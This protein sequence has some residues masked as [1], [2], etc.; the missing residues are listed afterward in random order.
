MKYIADLHVHSSYSRATSKE[1]DLEHLFIAAK[2]KGI[3]LVGTGDFTHPEWFTNLRNKLREKEQGIYE[4]KPE[5]EKSLE[6]KYPEHFVNPVRFILVSEISNI[7]KKDGKVRKIHNLVF[8]PDLDSAEKFNTK[9]SAIGNIKSDGRPILGL[10][11]RDLLEIVLETNENA[12]L[13]PAHIWTPWFSILGSKSGFDGIEECF[14]DLTQHIFALETGLSSDPAMNWRISGL[15]GYTLISNS[16]AHSPMNLGREAN[17]FNTELSYN[18]LKKALET[19]DK[20]RFLGTFE[21]FPEEGKYHLDGHRNCGIRL[22]PYESNKNGLKCPKCGKSLTLGVMY[23]VDELSDRPEGFQ[24]ENA[25]PFKRLV[26][27][28][29]IISEVMKKGVKT[30]GVVNTYH[31]LIKELGP[32]FDI[33]ESIPLETI[34]KKGKKIGIPLLGEAVKRVREGNIDI[35][36]GYDGEYGT[37]NIF[38]KNEWD[39]LIGQANLFASEPTKQ[40]IIK[41]RKLDEKIKENEK[42]QVLTIFDIKTITKPDKNDE[43]GNILSGLNEEQFKAVNA[44]SGPLMIVAGPGTGKTRT[45]TA[46]IVSII[47]S[48]SIRSENIA[49]VTFTT[50]AAGEMQERLKNSLTESNLPLVSTFHGLAYGIMKE[51]IGKEPMI[52]D[53]NTKD[54]F[55]R[56]IFR[57][58]S[59]IPVKDRKFYTSAISFLKQRL[60]PPDELK[61]ETV[62]LPEYPEADILTL[63]QIYM[64]YDDILIKNGVLDFDSLIFETIRRLRSDEKMICS[65]Q[66]TIKSL[67]VDEFQ[68]INKSQF[69]LIKMIAPTGKNLTVIGDPNQAIYGF[70]GSDVRFFDTFIKNFPDTSRITL[71]RN[72][73][74]TESILKASS[75]IIKD[76]G[77]LFSGIEGIRKLTVMEAG[78]EKEEAVIIGKQIEKMIG[79]MGMYSMDMNK[80]DDPNCDVSRSF[81]DI[82]ILYRLSSQSH[83]FEEV[84]DKAGIPYQVA[85]REKWLENPRVGAILII[86][87]LMDLMEKKNENDD[88]NDLGTDQNFL[89]DQL[90]K[91][92]P[93]QDE[94]MKHALLQDFN[95]MVNNGFYDL[96]MRKKIDMIN[97]V[98]SKRFAPL[99]DKRGKEAVAGLLETASDQNG[100]L[101]RFLTSLALI[102]DTDLY[103]DKIQ[104][105]TLMTMHASKGLEF[106]VVFIAGCEEGLTPYEKPGQGVVDMD[107]ERRLFYVAMTRARESLYLTHTIKRTMHGNTSKRRLSQFVGEIEKVLLNH[108]KNISVKKKKSPYKQLD[109][110]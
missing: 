63:R 22:N 39:G 103:D 87:K 86:M 79:G 46:R 47:Q 54:I 41:K 32:E 68:D 57:M 53:E 70:S 85:S 30:K 8:M 52:V 105:V 66:K 93:K 37:I 88:R 6:K 42:N 61:S 104:K 45:L 97:K 77:M 19:G 71:K 59:G 24:P 108:E 48:G 106:S 7:Y 96:S 89:M 99:K 98:L 109:L 27:L 14:G 17:I 1:L 55:L 76:N 18:A 107:E 13:I 94:T 31:T 65:L 26:T 34:E 91:D 56:E 25:I 58:Y 28:D 44:G 102:R 36:P 16:D 40:K 110:F 21:F 2:L 35:H 5:T 69:E 11:S 60:I 84:F 100:D 73:R 90:L 81:S 23:R 72:Y 3:T 43:N 74:S 33:L 20:K 80:V 38:D 29:K 12:F 62:I 95:M 92:N 49:A 75:Q 64:A 101:G 67:F 9:L 50:K 51:Y 10:D 78:N 4:L 15:D 83:V 82:A